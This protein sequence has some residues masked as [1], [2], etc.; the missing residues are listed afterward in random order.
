MHSLRPCESGSNRIENLIFLCF[1]FL[2]FYRVKDIKYEK[3]FLKLK[4]SFIN[5]FGYFF[6]HLIQKIIGLSLL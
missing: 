1:F 6:L 5:G 4:N 3:L 2:L